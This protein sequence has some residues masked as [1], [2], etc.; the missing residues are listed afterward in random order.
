MTKNAIIVADIGYGDAGKGSIVDF[1]VRQAESAVVVRYNGGPQAAHNVVTPDGRHHTFAQ[2]GSGS[3][4]PGV[5]THLSRFMLVN[6]INMLRE[7]RQ[8]ASLGA[9]DIWHRL[10]V[11]DGAVVILPWHQAANRLRELARGNGR[12]GSCGQGVGEARSEALRYPDAAIR[13]KHLQDV[14]A[15]PAK[16]KEHRAALYQRLREELGNSD[17]I[18]SSEEWLPF[19]DAQL[20]PWLCQM[21]RTWTAWT[22]VVDAGYLAQL[23]ADH[24]QLVFEGAQG[25]LLDEAHGF[26][27][28]TTWSNTTPSNAQR[29]LSEI[30]YTSP[31]TKLGVLRAYATRHGPGPFVTEDESLAEPLREQHNGLGQWQGA[32]RYGHIDLV[33]HRYAVDACHGFDGLAVTGL[34]RLQSLPSWRFASTYKLENAPADADAYIKRTVEGAVRNLKPGPTTTR[35]YQARLTELLASC[36]PIY[37]TISATSTR[38]DDRESRLLQVIATHLGVPIHIVSHG[39]TAADKHALV[40]R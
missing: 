4:V 18:V 35:S 39:P 14:K 6:P 32:F 29:L 23:A 37:Q 3:F 36:S 10:S 28:Y 25:V 21:F 12:H 17:A 34:D 5:R 26:Y 7:A 27:P 40:F 11:E 38:Y 24:E 31:V 19:T 1:L 15:L 13:V 22:N 30:G 9:Y 20:I 16:L 8:L 2:L 33:A